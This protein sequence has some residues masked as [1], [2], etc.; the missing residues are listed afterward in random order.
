MTKLKLS[1]VDQ[2]SAAAEKEI[3]H[4]PERYFGDQ[5]DN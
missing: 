4:G 1:S 5:E 2:S 3:E